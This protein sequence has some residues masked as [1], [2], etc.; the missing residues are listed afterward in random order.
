MN[1]TIIIRQIKEYT[2]A[3]GKAYTLLY[4]IGAVAILTSCVKDDLYDTPHPDRGAVVVTTD[5]SGKSTEADIPQAY[6]LRIGGR[7][8]NVSAATNVFDALLAPGGYGLT[9]YNSPEG[10]SIDGNK[11]TVNPVDLTGAIEPHP[12]YLFAS[13]QDISVVADDTLHV[14]APMRQY[15]NAL[16]RGFGSGYGNRRPECS[17]T[18][19][20]RFQAGRQQV[21]NLFPTARHRPDGNAYADGGHHFQQR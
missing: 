2:G 7:E 20:K 6:T 1:T 18:S 5:W 8:Q 21:H 12:G 14:T 4:L 10:I 11:A 16:R 13:H 15:G 17:G 9:V 19:N 3:Y